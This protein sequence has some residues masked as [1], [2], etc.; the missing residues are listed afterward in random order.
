MTGGVT[1]TTAKGVA[2]V[3]PGIRVTSSIKS[4]SGRHYYYDSNSGSDS[5]QR[6]CVC[7]GKHFGEDASRKLYVSNLHSKSK[8]PNLRRFF[9]KYV[10]S[11]IREVTMKKKKKLVDGLNVEVL[12]HKAIK[13]DY[14]LKK[15]MITQIEV[16]GQ[17]LVFEVGRLS[18]KDP[19]GSVFGILFCLLLIV[20]QNQL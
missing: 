8:S 5:S 7:C 6:D 11:D 2:P 9:D 10:D 14:V 20:K 3:I 1:K 4:H 18:A 16:D 15:R 17:D 19:R 13:V 12:M